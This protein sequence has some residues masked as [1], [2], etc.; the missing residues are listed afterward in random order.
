MSDGRGETRFGRRTFLWG[1]RTFVMG[2]LNVTPDSFS[3]DGLLTPGSEHVA[4]AVAQAAAMAEE[5]AD[6]LDIG[7]EST[8]PGHDPVALEDELRRV[9]PAV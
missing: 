3:G 6:M 1:Q 9:V 7:G 5:G 2:I 4:P 8:R